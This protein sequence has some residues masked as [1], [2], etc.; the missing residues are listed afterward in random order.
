MGSSSSHNSAQTFI[1]MKDERRMQVSTLMFYLHLSLIL[2]WYKPATQKDVCECVHTCIILFGIK[3]DISSAIRTHTLTHTCVKA[4]INKIKPLHGLLPSSCRSDL[5][6]SSF[7]HLAGKSRKAPLS[8]ILQPLRSSLEER[9]HCS[10]DS[11]EKPARLSD[12]AQQV[13]ASSAGKLLHC[14]YFPCCVVTHR[15]PVNRWTD[16]FFLP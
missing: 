16:F 11:N 7:S 8:T 5:L 1:S 12:G 13:T 15:G 2:H 10:G 3:A 4:C 9:Q 6:L 14:V